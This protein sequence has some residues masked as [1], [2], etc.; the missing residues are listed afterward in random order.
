MQIAFALCLLLAAQS[1]PARHEAELVFPLH[2][3]HNHAPGVV[4]CPNGDLFV[5]WYRGSG[6]RRADDVAV[7]GAWR[8]KGESKWSEPFV[9]ADTPGFPDCNTAMFIDDGQRGDP[10]ASHVGTINSLDQILRRCCGQLLLE[11]RQQFGGRTASVGGLC[12]RSQSGQCD[13]VR[14][15]FVA[16]QIAPAAASRDRARSVAAPRQ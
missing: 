8:A 11:A 9:L 13:R 12:R 4:E 6:E 14:T 16:D 10:L 2:A 3:Q 1:E 15:P 5:S 7:Y